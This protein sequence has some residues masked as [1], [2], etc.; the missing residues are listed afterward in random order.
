MSTGIPFQFPSRSID[1]QIVHCVFTGLAIAL[2]CH[3]HDAWADAYELELHLHSTEVE[4]EEFAASDAMLPV[5]AA[6]KGNRPVG[7]QFDFIGVAAEQPYWRLP[8]S[9]NPALLFL[10]IGTEELAPADFGS[11]ITWSLISVTGSGGGPAP[12]VFSMWDV[13]DFAAL[14]PL[15]SSL[16]GAG[17]P[18]SLVVSAGGHYH[19]NYGFTAPGLYN[20]AFA[21]TAT[22]SEALGGGPVSGTAVYSFGV[23]DTGADYVEPSSTPWTYQGQEF[24]VALFGDEHID[25]GVGLAPVPEPSAAALAGIG[26]AAVGVGALRRRAQSSGK[27]G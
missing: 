17:T 22:L 21:A 3:C 16:P 26:L 19:Y 25:M 8:K 4:P 5:K 7:S 14:V 12:G 23:F 11:T 6:A 1:L 10:S 15:M 13:D 2:S 20:V 27:T 18:N 24:T 9:Q